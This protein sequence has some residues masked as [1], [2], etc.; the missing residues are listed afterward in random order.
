MKNDDLDALR[1]KADDLLEKSR[2][3]RKGYSAYES[4]LVKEE[5]EPV[6]NHFKVN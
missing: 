5:P 4:D 3:N 1:G 6:P 2:R